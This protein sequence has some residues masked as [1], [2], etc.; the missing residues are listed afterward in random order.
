MKRYFTLLFLLFAACRLCAEDGYRLWLRYDPV[1]DP[2]L[3][4][5]YRHAITGIRV[6]G[7]SATA[8]AIKEELTLGLEGLLGRK[9]MLSP[10]PAANMIIAGTPATS[11]F[12]ASLPLKDRLLKAGPE[13]YILL[14]TPFD[15]N[16]CIVVAANTDIGLL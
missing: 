6:E 15:K 12:I 3:L 2:A 7:Q 11:A 10:A 5:M 16:N 8:G 13:G 1:K 4:E 9:I 14:S